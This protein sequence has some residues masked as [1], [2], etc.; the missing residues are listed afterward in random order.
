MLHLADVLVKAAVID[1][2]L[3]LGLDGPEAYQDQSPELTAALGAG[4]H[5]RDF[6]RLQFSDVNLSH[7]SIIYAQY[8]CVKARFSFSFHLD[9]YS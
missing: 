9:K 4:I 3:S 5:E 8:N 1:A 2:E 7:T 6:L